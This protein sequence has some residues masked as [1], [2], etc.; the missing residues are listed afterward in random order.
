[1][2]ECHDVLGEKLTVCQALKV[3]T[4]DEDNDDNAFFVPYEDEEEE[5]RTIPP[6]NASDFSCK[7]IDLDHIHDHLI[8]LEVLLPNRDLLCVGKI[9]R[10]CV[11][12]Q[13]K[14]VRSP[15]PNPA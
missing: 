15:H 7:F 6:Q 1:M 11:D 13:G 3:E 4:V 2:T 9:V 10:A 12:E 8:N 14:V 5:S